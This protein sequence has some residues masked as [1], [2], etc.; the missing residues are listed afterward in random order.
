[1]HQGSMLL[2]FVLNMVKRLLEQHTMKH[3][4]FLWED[5]FIR[6]SREYYP[7]C[8]FYLSC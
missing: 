8:G 2:A 3:Q 1:M 5:E 4:P 7:R 6:V